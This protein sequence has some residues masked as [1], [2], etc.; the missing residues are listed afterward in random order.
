MQFVREVSWCYD[1]NE[2]RI[3]LLNSR[4]GLGLQSCIDKLEANKSREEHKK[5]DDKSLYSSI[6]F[7]RVYVVSHQDSTI[8]HSNQKVRSNIHTVFN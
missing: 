7:L 2:S 1:K 5:F 6:F 8:K 3:K 4:R